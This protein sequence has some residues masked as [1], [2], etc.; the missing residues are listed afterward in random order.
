MEALRHMRNRIYFL[1][2]MLL[3]FPTGTVLA[4]AKQ[5]PAARPK[6]TRKAPAA[7]PKVTRKTRP[8]PRRRPRGRKRRPEAKKVTP[9]AGLPA[10]VAK[11]APRPRPRPAPRVEVVIKKSQVKKPAGL[12]DFI[13]RL[14]IIL[15]HLPIGWL[16]LLLLVDIG[17]FGLKLTEG[18]RAGALLLFG[19]FISLVPVVI[20]GFIRVTYV[21]TPDNLELLQLHRNL[22][23]GLV[24][25][26]LL[27]FLE[28]IRSRNK[29]EGS[30]KVFYLALVVAAVALLSI[31][32]YMGA[33]ISFGPHIFF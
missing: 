3:L 32:G 16:L 17:T 12:L 21:S 15:V 26:I 6:V 24:A 13:G 7:R 11:P 33:Q 20:T 23:L 25:V 18:V 30:P 8:A 10:V 19:T 28:R 22:S 5:G 31:G 9:D 1:V 2:A 4:Q 29:L 14:H 27:A